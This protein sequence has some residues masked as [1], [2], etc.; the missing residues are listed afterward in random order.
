MKNKA[1]EAGRRVWCILGLL[2]LI[3]LY[4]CSSNSPTIRITTDKSR[5]IREE[6][7]P[8]PTDQAVNQRVL[9]ISSTPKQSK[10]EMMNVQVNQ[11]LNLLVKAEE[12]FAEGKFPNAEKVMIEASTLIES[13]ELWSVLVRIYDSSGQKTKADSCRKLINSLD[14]LN[15]ADKLP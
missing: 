2:S 6:K 5:S 4:S 3:G 13:K 7:L 9:S 10:E 11:V 14:T 15:S 1:K 12:L 8:E